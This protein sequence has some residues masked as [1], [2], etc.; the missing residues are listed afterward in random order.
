MRATV[1]LKLISN[2][3]LGLNNVPII[4]YS[5][6]HGDDLSSYMSITFSLKV[7]QPLV[8]A[9]LRVRGRRAELFHYIRV[10]RRVQNLFLLRNIL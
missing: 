7:L 10:S 3:T 1:L 2:V 9:P 8:V 5:L 6:F 4:N